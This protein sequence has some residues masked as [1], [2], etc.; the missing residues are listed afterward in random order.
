MPTTSAQTDMERAPGAARR[1]G[2]IEMQSLPYE[3][4]GALTRA[5]VPHL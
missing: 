3:F 5:A 1:Y 4:V 2:S